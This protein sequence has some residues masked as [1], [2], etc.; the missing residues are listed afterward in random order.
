MTP[1]LYLP[2]PFRLRAFD[3][4]DSTNAE[5][6][7]EAEKGEN[8]IVVWAR[9][10]TAGRGRRG[11]AWDSP[12]GNLYCSFLLRPEFT[13]D[14][15]M[16]VGFVAAIALADTV[17]S[18]LPRSSF[19]HTKW[20]ND[21]LVEDRKISG[22][23][24]E[25]SLDGAGDLEWLVVGTGVN[26]ESFPEN[27]DYAATCLHAEGVDGI[28]EA[29]LLEIYCLRFLAWYVTWKKLGFGPVRQAWLR[30]ARGLG[31]PVTVRLPNETIEGTFEA[32]DED[33]ALILN[34]D[35]AQR[36]ILAGDIFPARMP[37]PRRGTV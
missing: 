19:V 29:K 17:A 10:Q 37:E 30:R 5:A 16:R 32:M 28:N 34:V 20:P 15:A 18:I 27:A 25:S 4:I 6:C 26:I 1:D 21:V 13:P 31:E 35:G 23:L 8:H 9:E 2:S 22:I 11:R 12:R 33:G 7:R 3:S 14:V 36:R 24:M